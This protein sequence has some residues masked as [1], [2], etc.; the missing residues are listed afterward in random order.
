MKSKE[1]EAFAPLICAGDR[2][3]SKGVA[4]VDDSVAEST[5]IE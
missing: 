2:S 5:L 1:D 3:G 4:E